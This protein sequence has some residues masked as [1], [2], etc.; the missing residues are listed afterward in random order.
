MCEMKDDVGA[1]ALNETDG[2]GSGASKEGISHVKKGP[3]GAVLT[4]QSLNVPRHLTLTS[5]NHLTRCT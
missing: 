3:G 4:W 5:P 2:L 1:M